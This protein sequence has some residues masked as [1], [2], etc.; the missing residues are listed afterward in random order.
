MIAGAASF[1]YLAPQAEKVSLGVVSQA[2][3][4]RVGDEDGDDDQRDD[5]PVHDIERTLG[6]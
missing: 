1:Q 6:R 5:P 2:L 3:P 4:E